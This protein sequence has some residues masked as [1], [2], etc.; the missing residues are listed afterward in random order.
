[1]ENVKTWGENSD[2]VL[3]ECH[4]KPENCGADSHDPR[5]GEGIGRQSVG[6]GQTVHV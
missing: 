4:P 6:D 5:F 2:G 1:M 3:A